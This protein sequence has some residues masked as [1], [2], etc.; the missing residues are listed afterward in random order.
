[1]FGANPD[2][3]YG[4]EPKKLSLSFKKSQRDKIEQALSRKKI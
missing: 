2:K 1:M 4:D 3:L